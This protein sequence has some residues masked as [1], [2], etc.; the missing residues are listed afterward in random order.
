MPAHGAAPAARPGKDAAAAA[1]KP[2]KSRTLADAPDTRASV[3]ATAGPKRQQA[4][5]SRLEQSQQAPAG[6]VATASSAQA[7][8][9]EPDW[10]DDGGDKENASPAVEGPAGSPEHAAA[11]VR[12]FQRS[13]TAPARTQPVARATLYG[14]GG[15]TTRHASLMSSA[16]APSSLRVVA[17]LG[18]RHRSVQRT[19]FASG[20]SGGAG[21]SRPPDRGQADPG[22]PADASA[23]GAEDQENMPPAAVTDQQSDTSVEKSVRIQRS[24]SGRVPFGVLFQR[25]PDAG[26]M[27]VSQAPP[28]AVDPESAESEQD[29]G[30]D[31]G[32]A[33]AAAP[34]LDAGRGDGSG[35][36]DSSDQAIASPVSRTSR[37]STGGSDAPSGA[38]SS[39]AAA[40]GGDDNDGSVPDT[41]RT[42][43]RSLGRVRDSPM[44]PGL[45]AEE[46][47]EIASLHMSPIGRPSHA[48]TI[49]WGDEDEVVSGLA[50][51]TPR[52]PHAQQG[53]QALR[54]IMAQLEHP[55]DPLA[56]IDLSLIAK[57]GRAQGPSA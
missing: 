4:M 7:D 3:A 41:A 40:R 10:D 57:R 22:S 13:Q 12:T 18:G 8:L 44:R 17:A 27:P 30:D 20:G 14:P 19:L 48:G 37:P 49:G 26:E 36:N 45:D 42:V 29:A 56:S 52:A 55:R 43:R 2:T 39:G 50:Q 34:D 47:I 28:S 31:S 32:A 6:A 53:T 5:R 15:N 33:G 35:L 21:R 11:D 1:A 38:D 16:D 25:G 54:T 24:V 23:S 46:D 9:S 51:A